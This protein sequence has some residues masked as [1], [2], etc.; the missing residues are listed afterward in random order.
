MATKSSAANMSKVPADFHLLSEAEQAELVARDFG[1]D[2]KIA[3]AEAAAKA[4][5]AAE[6]KKASAEKAVSKG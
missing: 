2:P 1:P 4:K 3:E 5:A 6:A